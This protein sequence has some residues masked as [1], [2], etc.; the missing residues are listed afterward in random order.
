MQLDKPGVVIG[1]GVEFDGI[2]VC[3]GEDPDDGA[4]GA[5]IVGV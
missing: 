2:V 3:V 5:E 1:C 4:G